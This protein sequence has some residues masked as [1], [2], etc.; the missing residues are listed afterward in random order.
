[1]TNP[2]APDAIRHSQESIAGHA[3]CMEAY[4]EIG[5][6]PVP[7]FDRTV[8]DIVHS[9][10]ARPSITWQVFAGGTTDEVQAWMGDPT[11]SDHA[12]LYWSWWDTDRSLGALR[13]AIAG[14]VD[15]WTPFCQ[16][17][18]PIL[19]LVS[20]SGPF[21]TK[22]VPGDRYQ[23]NQDTLQN[24]GN[25]PLTVSVQVTYAA[26]AGMA[27]VR[28]YNFDSADWRATRASAPI[29]TRDLQTG[30]A[31]NSDMW[32]AMS[33]A[34]ELIGRLEPQL[35]GFKDEPPDLGSAFVTTLRRGRG[36]LLMTV[37]F[38]DA[39][40]SFTVDLNPY[41]SSATRYD[42]VLDQLQVASDVPL[43]ETRTAEPGECIAW[44]LER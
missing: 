28:L 37:N 40:Q 15:D 8:M 13:R 21:Y 7:D 3:I 38:S 6:L 30:I 33:R 19:L 29:G 35:F 10:R 32:N 43:S 11:M 18:R 5:G 1:L 42:L 39:A 27:G 12:T 20:S 2:W 17:D 4:D 31:P 36:V 23:E 25:T 44:V 22:N 24:P 26:I 16:Q 14:T 41:G 34:F 9:A